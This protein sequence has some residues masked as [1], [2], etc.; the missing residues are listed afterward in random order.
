MVGLFLKT[1]EFRKAF[2]RLWFNLYVQVFNFGVVS[3]I[4]FGVSRLLVE[5]GV[6]P[7]SLADGLVAST[8]VPMTVNMVFILTKTAGGNEAAAVFNAAFGNMVG[9]FLSPLLILAYLGVRGGVDIGTVF[10]K[11]AL[12]VLLPLAVGQ[13][14]QK[15]APETLQRVV[16]QHGQLIK[17]LQQYSIIFIVYTVF[18]RTFQSDV[19]AGVRD[20]VLMIVFELILL[21]SLMALAWFT[22]GLVFRDQPGLRVMGLFGCTHKTVALGVPLI[23]AIYENSPDVGLFT[24]PL[25]IWH[26]MQLLVGS[27]LVPRL[28]E[29][30]E[31]E[32]ERLGGTNNNNNDSSSSVEASTTS[33][34]L[35]DANVCISETEQQQKQVV[36]VEEAA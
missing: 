35:P 6:L 20:I 5:L 29:Y 31:R 26:P 27:L 19:S 18:C 10:Y 7:S 25:L 28:L 16:Q 8:S 21:C 17:K 23:G 32:K 9:V 4:V 15:M 34:E 13:A 22:L 1:E 3:S 30:G 24:L 2:Q 11:L 33:R 12:R 14:A 36:N